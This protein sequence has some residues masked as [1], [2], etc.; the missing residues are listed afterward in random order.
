MS[1]RKNFSLSA[2]GPA[3]A[4]T[5]LSALKV[6]SASQRSCQAVSMESASSAV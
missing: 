6:P 1:S 5:G 2:P 3:R 4:P